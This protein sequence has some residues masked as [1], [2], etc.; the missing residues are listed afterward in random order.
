MEAT[1]QKPLVLV[2]LIAFAIAGCGSGGGDGPGSDATIP[3]DAGL[4]PDS[5]G[6]APDA[7]EECP[8]GCNYG[9][10]CVA[11]VC[12]PSD[13]GDAADGGSPDAE[14][15]DGGDVTV[16]SGSDPGQFV[17]RGMVVTPDQ[18]LD[19]GEVYLSN[20]RLVCVR[21]DC[22][23]FYDYGANAGKATFIDTAGII[24]PGLINPHNHMAYN[25]LPRYE[26]GRYFQNRYQWQALEEYREVMLKP[27]D[28]L[29]YAGLIC[30]MVKFAETIEILAGVTAAQGTSHTG[31]C[32]SLMVRNM[33]ND[34][35]GF[36]LHRVADRVPKI[37]NMKDDDAREVADDLKSGKLK[38][39]VV[40]IGEGI[41]DSSRAELDT[42]DA[43]GL[44]LPQTAII[45][46]TGFGDAQWDKM[47]AAGARL[48]WSPYSNVSLY[49]I[50]TDAAEAS[51]KGIEVSLGPDWNPSGSKNLLD[52]VRYAVKYN[53]E[54]LGSHFTVQDIVRMVTVNP[55]R[56]LGFD[57][58]IGGL[59]E[60]LTADVSVFKRRKVDFFEAF[61]DLSAE[62]VELVLIGG[63]PLHGR[64]DW[65][66][67][68]PK[69]DFCEPVDVCGIPKTVCMKTSE[70]VDAKLKFHHTLSDVIS[71]LKAE[72]GG[73][74]E[75][76]T[77][78]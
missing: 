47:K 7:G 1:V 73:L 42:L 48:I 12:V 50:A 3:T 70:N 74:T 44:L 23:Q 21:T 68:I 69:P 34:Y 25:V 29:K 28:D 9:E 4:R 62:D 56:A 39:F 18:V 71:A 19:P 72:Y 40:H 5:G 64:R 60:G 20:G 8:F 58:L 65:M 14:T 13:A 45:H 75:L 46:G 76:V 31:E 51:K 17:L 27:F 53:T 6:P 16:V 43:K 33:D 24:L 35:N 37:G 52:E 59:K 49:N 32:E 11:G 10:V 38:A 30:E 66:D 41:D 57:D 78:R 61:V 55:A 63:K 67:T 26:F 36:G 54:W 2:A 77:C 15:F 22:S